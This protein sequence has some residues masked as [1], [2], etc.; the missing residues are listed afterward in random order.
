MSNIKKNVTNTLLGIGIFAVAVTTFNIVVKVAKAIKGTKN[1]NDGEETSAK[2][3]FENANAQR[4]ECTSE[5]CDCA[6]ESSGR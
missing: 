3:L 4:N 5:C 6:C 1:V 2:P